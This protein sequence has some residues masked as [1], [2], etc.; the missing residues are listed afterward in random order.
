MAAVSSQNRLRTVAILSK[1]QASRRAIPN[2]YLY[3]DG[4]GTVNPVHASRHR[5]R[6]R[7][8]RDRGIY[9]GSICRSVS[10]RICFPV[11]H[12]PSP[13]CA[14]VLLADVGATDL[15][16]LYFGLVARLDRRYRVGIY[17]AGALLCG[18]PSFVSSITRNQ[19]MI[20][21]RFACRRARGS[22]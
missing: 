21:V 8:G 9:C 15:V 10:F 7:S 14:P 22:G 12:R 11:V 17:R 4:N 1:R 20:E 18:S 3:A 19:T 6:N 2:H 13:T 16:A 5:P